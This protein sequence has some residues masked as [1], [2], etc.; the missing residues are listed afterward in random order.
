VRLSHFS[1]KNKDKI[2][3]MTKKRT[4]NAAGQA[5][6]LHAYAR[7]ISSLTMRHS[8]GSDAR[9]TRK[10]ANAHEQLL[11]SDQS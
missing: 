4:K 1:S 3:G 8:Q 11:K 9:E 5:K 2:A 7:K 6:S 10:R